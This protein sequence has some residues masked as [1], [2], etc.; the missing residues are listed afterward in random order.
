MKYQNDQILKYRNNLQDFLNESGKDATSVSDKTNK[1]I[2]QL[3]AN[4]PI[5][6]I[7]EDW[8]IPKTS[9][10]KALEVLV[11]EWCKSGKD[12]IQKIM[13]F[14]STINNNLIGIGRDTS[15]AEIYKTL[16]GIQTIS[17]ILKSFTYSGAGFLWEAFLAGIT[18]GEQVKLTNVLTEDVILEESDIIKKILNE[19][20]DVSIVDMTSGGDA[21]SIKL[22]SRSAGKLI[23]KGSKQKL[24]DAVNGYKN[25]VTYII[26]ARENNDI[27]LNFYAVNVNKNNVNYF[28]TST[29][30]KEFNVDPNNHEILDISNE[31]NTQ[32]SVRFGSKGFKAD[33]FNTLTLDRKD[34]IKYVKDNLAIIE[35]QLSP[36]YKDIGIFTSNLTLFFTADD[37][38]KRNIA[39]T[40]T[41]LAV[42]NLN[43][44]AKKLVKSKS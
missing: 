20:E 1:Q 43:T 9:D 19:A 5:L 28:L 21:Y 2:E 31:K 15:I 44:S 30:G 13:S 16:I 6:N 26:I 41:L 35:L 23:V 33:P 38:K 36:I 39:S 8:G 34:I 17:K 40:N 32:F 4:L 25:G 24:I 29:T 10:R 7:S 14:V 3:I 37:F 18:G 11:K 12:P 27:S 22:L 42:N